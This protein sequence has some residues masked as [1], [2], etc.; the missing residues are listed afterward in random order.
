MKTEYLT[1]E[2]YVKMFSDF[3]SLRKK[4]V[5]SLL[6]HG[7]MESKTILDLAAGHGYLSKAIYE[8][9]YKNKIIALGLSND[10]E[11]Y[12]HLR[13]SNVL[14][15]N[16]QYIECSSVQMGLKDESIDCIVNFL[17][18]EDINMTCGKDG[19]EKTL[20]ETS[21]IVKKGGFLEITLQ[22]EGEDPSS[23]VFWDLWEYIG[24]NAVFYSPSY[25]IDILESLGFQLIEK[26]ALGTYKKMTE[27]QAKEEIKFACNE[28]PKIFS[29]FHIK[30]KSFREVWKKFKPRI[31]EYGMGYW[32]EFLVLIF[33]KNG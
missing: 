31:K 19:V 28:T 15:K 25:Y 13:Q 10:T 9:G 30:A 27:C 2:E 18:L 24:I 4:I 23:R 3:C 22:I 32:P 26:F 33:R 7:L 20:R 21:R 29:E 1:D 12:N 16:I 6:K 11:A 17:G 14:M 5:I 8:H